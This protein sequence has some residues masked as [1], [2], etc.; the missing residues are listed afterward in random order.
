MEAKI[1]DHIWSIEELL[2]AA[3]LA[4]GMNGTQPDS[5]GCRQER[6]NMRVEFREF[7]YSF[8]RDGWS[9]KIP[10]QEAADFA[11]RLGREKLISI[12]PCLHGATVWYW[13]E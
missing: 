5:V 10:Y 12:S 8:F 6:W 11:T 7:R 1:T 4:S 3:Y 9:L 13:S 2:G